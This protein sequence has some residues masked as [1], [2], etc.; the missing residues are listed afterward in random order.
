MGPSLKF[1]RSFWMVSH[2]SSGLTAPLS[3]GVICEFAKGTVNLSMSLIKILNSIG[4]R[5]GLQRTP[6]ITGSHLDIEL[7]TETL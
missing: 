6:V 3:F 4:P 7:F 2:P 5:I 1:S